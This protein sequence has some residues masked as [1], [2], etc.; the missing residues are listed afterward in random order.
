MPA[1]AETAPIYMRSRRFDRLFVLGIP[2]LALAVG[3][4]ALGF[5][6]YFMLIISLDL[7]LLGYHHVISTYTRLLFDLKSA[8]Q[9]WALLLPLPV[10]VFA[11]VYLLIGWGGVAAVATLYMHWQWYHYTR[12]SEGINKA[13]GMKTRSVQAGNPVFNRITFYLVPAAAFLMMSARPDST[14]LGMEVW[15]LPVPQWLALATMAAAAACLAWWLAAQVRALRDGTLGRLH[16]AYLCSHYMIYLVSYVAIHDI[17]SGWLVINVWHNA[18]YIAFVWLFN[19][20]QFKGGV[21]PEQRALSWLSQE[22][23][24]PL[25]LMACLALTGVVYRSIDMSNAYFANYTLVPLVV[26]AYQGINFHHYIVDS[27]IWKLRKRDVQS[28]LKIV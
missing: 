25:Y 17:T 22:G 12:Q 15:K 20:N 3:A 5:P 26:I 2:L 24:W 11:G 13:Y 21:N 18:Q 1:I 10:A 4:L 23:R 14:F 19:S 28:A 27:I 6:H 8:R 16:F 9:H 7:A